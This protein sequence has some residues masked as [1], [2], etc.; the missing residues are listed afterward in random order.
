MLSDLYVYEVQRDQSILHSI[1]LRP[2]YPKGQW[3]Q[4]RKV[5][6]AV[7]EDGWLRLVDLTGT[8]ERQWGRSSSVYPRD[9][10]R[11]WAAYNPWCLSIHNVS[12]V[13]ATLLREGVIDEVVL[14]QYGRIVKTIRP[15]DRATEEDYETTKKE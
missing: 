6:A 7:R 10:T 11:I 1:R 3:L 14:D 13:A 12:T 4:P 15:E 5:L 8:N 9:V 2:I